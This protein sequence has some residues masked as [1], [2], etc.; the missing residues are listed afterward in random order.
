MRGQFLQRTGIHPQQPS[1]RPLRPR[2]TLSSKMIGRI[3]SS[4]WGHI[5]PIRRETSLR[6]AITRP[7]PR[8]QIAPFRPYRRPQGY[9]FFVGTTAECVLE[10]EGDD[11]DKFITFKAF[12]EVEDSSNRA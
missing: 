3:R 7:R 11:D 12:Y 1:S 2:P 4:G 8:Q 9:I 5:P 10:S 6:A